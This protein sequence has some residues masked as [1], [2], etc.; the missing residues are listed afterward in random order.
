MDQKYKIL[1]KHQLT[2]HRKAVKK[3]KYKIMD[4]KYIMTFRTVVLY[5]I[6]VHIIISYQQALCH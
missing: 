1:I 6:N 5:N 2:V 3:E 4:Q